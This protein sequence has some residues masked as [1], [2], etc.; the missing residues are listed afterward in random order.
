MLLLVVVVAICFCPSKSSKTEEPPK[1]EEFERTFEDF[2]ALFALFLLLFLIQFDRVSREDDFASS[3][4]DDE[5]SYDVGNASSSKPRKTNRWRRVV[6]CRR[7]GRSTAK[8]QCG[9]AL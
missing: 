4:D 7:C 2:C 9:H 5:E 3:S 8:R 1:A 6:S